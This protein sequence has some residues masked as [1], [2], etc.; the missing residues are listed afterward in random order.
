MSNEVPE[1]THEDARHWADEIL[2]LWNHLDADNPDAEAIFLVAL[3]VAA[4]TFVGNVAKDGVVE[5]V[6]GDFVH[7]FTLV[8]QAVHRQEATPDGGQMQ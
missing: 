5:E 2:G 4:G 7:N 8:A 3:A 1:Q 6:I